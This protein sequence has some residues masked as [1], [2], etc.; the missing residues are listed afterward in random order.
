MKALVRLLISRSLL[1]MRLQRV[2]GDTRW[3]LRL[4]RQ[5]RIQ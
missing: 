3:Q 1:E 2:V 5:L 4:I